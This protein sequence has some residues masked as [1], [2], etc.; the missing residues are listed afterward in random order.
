MQPNGLVS[1]EGFHAFLCQIIHSNIIVKAERSS[2]E[3]SLMKS[4]KPA[5]FP[6]PKVIKKSLRL[7]GNCGAK[8]LQELQGM[9]LNIIHSSST[10]KTPGMWDQ[11]GALIR[12]PRTTAM[13]VSG[14]G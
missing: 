4:A 2:K 9:S 10:G 7:M 11:F 3:G 6:L 12:I 14:S 8:I 5:S 1:A 13:E